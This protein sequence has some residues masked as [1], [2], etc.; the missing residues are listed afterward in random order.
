MEILAEN[1]GCQ[2]VSLPTIYLG[3]PLDAKNKEVEV[4]SEV[5]ERSERKLTRWKS[6]YLSLGGRL[7]LIKSV[8]DALPR[9]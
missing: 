8:M 9:T 7:T 2:L 6:Q 3:M 4:W 5:L 1:L